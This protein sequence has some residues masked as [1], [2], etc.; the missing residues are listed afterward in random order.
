LSYIKS[1]VLTHGIINEIMENAGIFMKIAQY[2]FMTF[3]I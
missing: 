2:F 3:S 1:I